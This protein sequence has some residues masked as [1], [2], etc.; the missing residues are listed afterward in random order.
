MSVSTHID[1][2]LVLQ[3][4]NSLVLPNFDLVIGIA[5]GGIVPA[6]LVALKLGCDLQLLQLNYRN[7]ANKPQYDTPNILNNVEATLTA[8]K[9]ILIVDDVSVSGKT[10]EFAK[11][12]IAKHHPKT[13]NTLV[14]KGKIGIAD[15]VL[16]HDITTC[17]NWAWTPAKEEVNK[18]QGEA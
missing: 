13:V 8:G 11:A 17:V 18:K 16:L 3:K 14:F 6:S 4:L 2:K 10:L 15:F 12:I 7:D 1:F 9:N 5:R